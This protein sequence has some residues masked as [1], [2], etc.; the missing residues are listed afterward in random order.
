MMLAKDLN[1]KEKDVRKIVTT[2]GWLCRIQSNGGII[3]EQNK[4]WFD[5]KVEDIK[6]Q[7]IELLRE[8]KAEEA[9]KFFEKDVK[10]LEKLLREAGVQIVGAAPAVVNATFYI[11]VPSLNG[12]YNKTALSVV[13]AGT[14]V[15]SNSGVTFQLIDDVDFTVTEI[16]HTPAKGRI[17]SREN[18]DGI[19]IDYDFRAVVLK[20]YETV[21]PS[22]GS[23]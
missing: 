12:S 2:F 14:T 22:T 10:N 8:N 23:S 9:K 7:I 21:S 16:N 19:L 13:K 18:S 1:I 11:K 20:R 5:K 6:N 3:T 4:V 17:I 15:A